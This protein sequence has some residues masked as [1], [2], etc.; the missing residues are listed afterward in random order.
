MKV[1]FYVSGKIKDFFIK[2][3]ESEFMDENDYLMSIIAIHYPGNDFDDVCIDS[4][5]KDHEKNIY[6]VNVSVW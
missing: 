5:E 3:V 6:I 4:I 2:D 1:L